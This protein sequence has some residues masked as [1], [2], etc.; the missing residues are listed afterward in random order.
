M[1]VKIQMSIFEHILRVLGSWVCGKHGLKRQRF[2][3]QQLKPGSRIMAGASAGA[4][5]HGDPVLCDCA[6]SGRGR[7]NV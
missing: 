3:L 5:A 6:Q 1:E 7:W 4:G 2:D